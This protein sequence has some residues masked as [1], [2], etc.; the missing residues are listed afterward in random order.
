M[1]NALDDDIVEVYNAFMTNFTIAAQGPLQTARLTVNHIRTNP[2]AEPTLRVLLLGGSNFDL[3]LK[4]DF[5]TTLL[6]KRF[7]VLTYEPRGLGQTEQPAGNWTMDDYAADALS[8]L[9]AAGWSNAII[10]GESF[11]AMTA[12][13]LAQLAPQRLQAMILASG[14]PGGAGGSSYDISE[15]LNLPSNELAERSLLL[16]DTRNVELKKTDS[17]AFHEKLEQRIAL[18][19]QFFTPSIMSGGYAK[20]LAA[21]SMHNAWD[22][23]ADINMPTLV[24]AGAHDLQAPPTVQK[25]MASAIKNATYKE[26]SAGHGLLFTDPSVLLFVLDEWLSSLPALEP[27]K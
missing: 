10:L 5:L 4:R 13:H 7:S 15:F 20:L 23:L 6:P 1:H 19:E 11:G 18:D 14:A 25:K 26:F 17:G 24:L 2:I 27:I 3:R 22:Y 8:V 9:D 12:L 16:Q 21:R